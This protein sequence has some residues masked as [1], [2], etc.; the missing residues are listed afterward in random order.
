VTR[1]LDVTLSDVKKYHKLFDKDN[2]DDKKRR[3]SYSCLQN[4]R[5]CVSQFVTKNCRKLVSEISVEWLSKA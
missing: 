4:Q 5:F 3:Y 2:R 1:N